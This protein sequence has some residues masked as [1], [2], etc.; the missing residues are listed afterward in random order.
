MCLHA[1]TFVHGW[2]L[3]QGGVGGGD[4]PTQKCVLNARR[5]THKHTDTRPHTHKHAH[6]RTQATHNRIWHAHAP[7]SVV[8]LHALLARQCHRRGVLVRDRVV[9]QG[10]VGEAPLVQG[11]RRAAERRRSPRRRRGRLVGVRTSAGGRA[12]ARGR[13]RECCLRML[14]GLMGHRA[15]TRTK[16]AT[17]VVIGA[18]IISR[19]HGCCR[20]HLRV[21]G[22]DWSSH[23]AH[24]GQRGAPYSESC[25][26]TLRAYGRRSEKLSR[27]CLH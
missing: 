15:H 3:L 24:R 18:V 2:V 10:V 16:Q 13:W 5:K 17:R 27:M 1:G 11:R 9:I 8:S 20:P 14:R 4:T 23:R 12:G 7:A 25:S 22:C 21:R 26:R 19:R 6:V